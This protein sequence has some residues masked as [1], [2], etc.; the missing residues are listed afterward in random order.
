MGGKFPS[1]GDFSIPSEVYDIHEWVTDELIDGETASNCIL[2]FPEKREECDNCIFDPNINASSSI[3]KQGGPIPFANYGICPRCQGNGFLSTPSTE[4]IRLRIY[5]NESNW[6]KFGFSVANPSASCMVIGYMSDLPS[7]E[8]ANTIL[9][10][11]EISGIRNF[12]CSREGE[13]QPWGFRRNRYFRQ[14]LTRCGG[15]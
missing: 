9:L 7:L 2:I 1:L 13:S 11:D 5:W 6:D 14:M 10:N 15:G 12:L 3:H 4:T 8:R